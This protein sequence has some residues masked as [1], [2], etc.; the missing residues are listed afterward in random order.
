MPSFVLSF[1]E[2]SKSEAIIDAYK[3]GYLHCADETTP[4]Y[5][6]CPDSPPVEGGAEEQAAG[7]DE[8]EEDAVDE[9]MKA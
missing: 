3:L 8:A 1:A 4:L 6:L 2:K 5:L 9:M 7:E